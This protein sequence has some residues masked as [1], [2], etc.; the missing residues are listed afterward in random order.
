MDET[1]ATCSNDHLVP[2]AFLICSLNICRRRD[3][4]DGLFPSVAI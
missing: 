4:F 1:I 2:L 3:L